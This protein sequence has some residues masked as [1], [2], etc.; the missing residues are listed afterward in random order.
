MKAAEHR[1]L[2]RLGVGCPARGAGSGCA[3]ATPSSA[4]VDDGTI[5]PNSAAAEPAWTAH[6]HSPGCEASSIA[7]VVKVERRPDGGWR[8]TCL[9]CQTLWVYYFDAGRVDANGRPVI[10]EGPCLYQYPTKH[11]L[12]GVPA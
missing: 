10:Q 4:H 11:M 5:D 6:K 2:R 1:M 3:A 9:A 12:T 8:S 7:L